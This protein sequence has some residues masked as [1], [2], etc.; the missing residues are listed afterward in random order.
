[1]G[2]SLP[3]CETDGTLRLPA[4]D[5]EYVVAVTESLRG[6]AARQHREKNKERRGCCSQT[7]TNSRGSCARTHTGPCSVCGGVWISCE[8]KEELL[9]DLFFLSRNC[10]SGFMKIILVSKGK[11]RRRRARVE[12][13]KRWQLSGLFCQVG[14]CQQSENTVKKGPTK[15]QSQNGSPLGENSPDPN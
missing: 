13:E 6:E 2:P 10:I 4:D 5:P 8:S 9:S 7:G 15:T 14:T 1:M 11:V 3:N 12:I